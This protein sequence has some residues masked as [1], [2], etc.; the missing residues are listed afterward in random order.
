MARSK[1]IIRE[2]NDTQKPHIR[3]IYSPRKNVQVWRELE[4]YESRIEKLEKKRKQ[5][6]EQA[7]ISELMQF[8]ENM[9][10]NGLRT[11]DTPYGEPRMVEY[12]SAANIM[13]EYKPQGLPCAFIGDHIYDQNNSDITDVSRDSES[14]KYS[15]FD[16]EDANVPD[17][18]DTR[19]SDDWVRI[20]TEEVH[21]KY[22]FH[23]IYY[24]YTNN[25]ALLISGPRRYFLTGC[26]NFKSCYFSAFFL[27]SM[28][29]NM[30]SQE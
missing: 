30:C 21:Y 20:S 13:L 23:K 11:V 10:K 3:R 25:D 26:T 14:S 22:D 8:K 15:D 6:R 28:Q 16:D 27:S 24:I 9:D 12:K 1:G 4:K 5:M 7:K 18:G 17:F 2:K 29:E 19:E